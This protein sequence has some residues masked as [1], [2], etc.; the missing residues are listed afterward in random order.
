MK[1]KLSEAEVQSRLEAFPAW[2][3]SDGRLERRFAFADFVEAFGFL[4]RVALLAERLNH[5]P[6]ITNS[7]KHVT[8]ALT[9]HD[10]GGVTERDFRLLA[11][12]EALP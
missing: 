7:Y 4:A 9:S 11:A 3:F 6:D 5:H 8:L 10:A 12:I 1:D 2:R